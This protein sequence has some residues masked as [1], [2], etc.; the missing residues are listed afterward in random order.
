VGEEGRP[1]PQLA[2]FLEG[3]DAQA[4]RFV[5]KREQQRA[6]VAMRS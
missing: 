2:A 4:S 6:R 3:L 5:E 1:L